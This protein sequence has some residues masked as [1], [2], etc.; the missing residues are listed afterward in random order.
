[1]EI[2]HKR[3]LFCVEIS[4]KLAA[5]FVEFV[6]TKQNIFIGNFSMK[7]ERHLEGFLQQNSLNF[8]ENF[9]K[10]HETAKKNCA[11]TLPCCKGFCG[12]LPVNIVKYPNLKINC[13]PYVVKYR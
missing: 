12:S 2:N 10:I 11:A 13:G 6:L 4:N 3:Q 5:V 7:T 1:M 9:D 8:G